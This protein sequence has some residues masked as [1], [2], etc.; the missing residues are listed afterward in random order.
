MICLYCLLGVYTVCMYVYAA[1]T[2]AFTWKYIHMYVCIYVLYMYVR[3]S[4]GFGSSQA[5][6]G[7]IARNISFHY[8]THGR[9]GQRVVIKSSYET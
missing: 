2:L 4:K 3:I 5:E 1:F 6:R 8:W 7:N 9:M